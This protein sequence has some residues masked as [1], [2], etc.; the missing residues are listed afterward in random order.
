MH[1]RRA[2]LLFAI[3]L[4]LAAIAASVTRP[5]D[6]PSR[7]NEPVSP[8]AAT[9]RAQPPTVAP[10]SAAPERPIDAVT[11]AAGGEDALWIPAG[12]GATVLVEVE[13]PGEVQIPDLGL[14]APAAPLT[15]ARFEIF[16]AEPGSH[17]VLVTSAAGD[18]PREVGTLTVE[19]DEG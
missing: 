18:E 13:E 4:A 2:L 9:E 10:G 8:P 12:R 19:A 17:E 3:V 16:A 11:F 15:P 7:S 5:G 14:S 1:L 6:E